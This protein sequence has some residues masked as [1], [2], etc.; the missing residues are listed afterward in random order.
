MSLIEDMFINVKNL[1]FIEIEIKN[2]P[3]QKKLLILEKQDV[4]FNYLGVSTKNLVYGKLRFNVFIIII[5]TLRTPPFM[6][7]TEKSVSTKKNPW[8]T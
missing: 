6:Q 3:H 5:P 1:E 8:K 2:I 7:F 4:L